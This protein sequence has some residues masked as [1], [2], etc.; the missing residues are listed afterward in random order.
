MIYS[1]LLINVSY[2]F[3]FLKRLLSELSIRC[4]RDFGYEILVLHLSNILVQFYFVDIK[5]YGSY[6]SIVISFIKAIKIVIDLM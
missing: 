3:V 1:T 2:E 6:Y 4:P 5:V